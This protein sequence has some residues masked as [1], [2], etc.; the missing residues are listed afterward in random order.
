[1]ALKLS[2]SVVPLAQLH[3]GLVDAG[4]YEILISS[5][6]RIKVKRET[7]NRGLVMLELTI[8]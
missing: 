1:M 2:N 5:R 6:T 4:V 3:E 8:L 7:H